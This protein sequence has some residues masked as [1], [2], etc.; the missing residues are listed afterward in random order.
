MTLNFKM[1]QATGLALLAAMMASCSVRQGTEYA[2][3]VD[4]TYVHKYGVAVPSDYWQSA[5]ADGAVVSTMDDGVVVT[6][7]YSGGTLDGDTTY[8]YPHS[9]QIQYGETYQKGTLV[10]E[11]EYYF[12]GTPKEE[13]A[14]DPSQ[15]G[16]KIVSA[17]YLTG[18]PRCIERY[19]N[20]ML[21]NGEYFTSS[22]QRDSI[23]DQSHGTRLLRDDY[24]QLIATDTIT[25]GKMVQRVVYHPNGSPREIIPYK[26][27][28]VEGTKK[29]FL[30][31]GEPNTV[32]QW[33]GG[34]QQG[35]TVVY[36][37]GE[38]YSETPYVAGEKNGVEVRYRD[39]HTKM[40]EITW[41]AGKM[42]GPTTTYAG[43][44]A[45]TDWYFKGKQTTKAD[46]DFMSN[47]PTAR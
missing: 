17:W 24:G 22:N 29:T 20:E 2:N 12:D 4:Q 7:R 45:K 30:P 37:H 40:Q 3:V 42:H 36:Q 11:T 15:A 21:Y 35:T 16:T 1:R 43:D 34:Q 41:S 10:K 13:T 27:G 8:T 38:V 39:G 19:Q 14:Y 26:N 18:T 28:A 46:F 9:S 6:R 33:V 47:K 32:E 44:V 5:G 31:A 25:D 23:V